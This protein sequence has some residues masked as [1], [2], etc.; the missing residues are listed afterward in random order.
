MK[1]LLASKW[2]KFT[3]IALLAVAIAAAS[4]AGTYF[5]MSRDRHQ[6]EEA[7]ALSPFDE[8]VEALKKQAH[9]GVADNFS[10]D[11]MIVVGEMLK[12]LLVSDD[13][14]FLTNDTFNSTEFSVDLT[15]HSLRDGATIRII[16]YVLNN[17]DDWFLGKQ[18]RFFM[19]LVGERTL[20]SDIRHVSNEGDIYAFENNDGVFI[21]V[22]NRSSLSETDTLSGWHAWM[23]MFENGEFS[24]GNSINIPLYCYPQNR[25]VLK[26]R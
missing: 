25:V 7:V 13:A 23:Y 26:Q 2:A 16:R 14:D 11:T 21:F 10:G 18:T 22:L 24:E 5:Y 17:K 15:D 19:Q 9:E 1:K 6:D 8:A 12:E 4:V 3:V 20:L